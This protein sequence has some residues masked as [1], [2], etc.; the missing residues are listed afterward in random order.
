MSE[1]LQCGC[2]VGMVNCVKSFNPGWTD[3]SKSKASN[4]QKL[5]HS[6]PKSHPRNRNAKYSN[7]T[8]R[9]MVIRIS[10]S[11]PNGDHSAS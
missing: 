4:E 8:K 6:E 10:S 9:Y 3:R 2:F 5:M 11:S 1:K 7:N